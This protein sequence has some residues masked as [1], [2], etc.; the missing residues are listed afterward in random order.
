[1][2]VRTQ[3]SVPVSGNHVVGIK[4]TLGTCAGGPGGIRAVVSG[5]TKRQTHQIRVASAPHRRASLESNRRTENK[6]TQNKPL[7]NQSVTTV[8]H[9]RPLRGRLVVVS[10]NMFLTRRAWRKQWF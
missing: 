3:N 5:E 4:K 6:P 8:A 7:R 1:M 2:S 10:A 9:Y